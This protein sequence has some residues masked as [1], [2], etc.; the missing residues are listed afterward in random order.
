MNTQTFNKLISGA[1]VLM[2]VAS[3]AVLLLNQGFKYTY[4]HPHFVIK[5]EGENLDNVFNEFSLKQGVSKIDRERKKLELQEMTKTQVQ[6]ITTELAAKEEVDKATLVYEQEI[7]PFEISGRLSVG[8]IGGVTIILA[9]IYFTVFRH[10][11]KLGAKQAWLFGLL[12]LVGLYTGLFISAGLLSAVSNYYQLTPVSFTAIGIAFFWGML[13][14]Q[15]GLRKVLTDSP[16]GLPSVKDMLRNTMQ[17]VGD[18][19]KMSAAVWAILLIGI[20]FGLGVKFAPEAVLIGLAL[21]ITA[22]SIYFIP[23]FI[24]LAVTSSFKVFNRSKP[25]QLPS[26]KPAKSKKRK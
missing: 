26:N 2:L 6:A 13:L 9:F 20:T 12:L 19:A 3:L 10:L 14:I 24:H 21:M 16:A 1:L 15:L 25:R 23:D 8:L 11:I 22:S 18:M 4:Y 7:I 5:L 17:E